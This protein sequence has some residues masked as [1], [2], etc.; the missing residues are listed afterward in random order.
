MIEYIGEEAFQQLKKSAGDRCLIILEGLDEMAANRQ[1]CDRFFIRLITECTVLEKATIVIT[2][3]PHACKNINVDRQV[4]VIGFGID[5]IKEFTEQS[6]HGNE[7]SVGKFLQQLHEYP[8][9]QSLCY[10]PLNLV[11]LLDIFQ[12]NCGKLPATLTELYKLFILMM[13]QRQILKVDGMCASAEVTVIASHH[14]ALSRILAGIPKQVI[15]TIFCFVSCLFMDFLIGA[16]TMKKR[17]HSALKR[18]GKTQ[19]LCLPW[20]T[21]PIVA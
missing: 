13:L 5:E 19:E 14:A 8:H 10:V 20:R 16:V 9:L 4:E 18:G 21:L 15:G 6:F 7:L 1:K 17:M 2:S 3:R 12:Y 11:M